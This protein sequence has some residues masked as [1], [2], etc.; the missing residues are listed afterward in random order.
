MKPSL[1]NYVNLAQIWAISDEVVDVDDDLYSAKKYAERAADVAQCYYQP[2]RR[3]NLNKN[4][5]TTVN[6]SSHP[7]TVCSDAGGDLVGG[8]T[9]TISLSMDKT[10]GENDCWTYEIHLPIGNAIPTINWQTTDGKIIRWMAYS[11]K[12]PQLTN[13]TAM[14]VIRNQGGL[15]IANY[16]GAY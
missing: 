15:L 7:I 5:T 9:Y 6:I 1:Q 10:T 3:V 13:A 4:A 12:T 14:F 2:I 8:N 11:P 16:S